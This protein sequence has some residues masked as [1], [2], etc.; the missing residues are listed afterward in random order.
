MAN[1]GNNDLSQAIAALT[2]Q[3]GDLTRRLEAS[4][5]V[6]DGL[7]RRLREVEG[8]VN[9]DAA[10]VQRGRSLEREREPRRELSRARRV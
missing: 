6:T 3:M 10:L 4:N 7:T 2:Q 1:E 8:T 5:Q 9:A